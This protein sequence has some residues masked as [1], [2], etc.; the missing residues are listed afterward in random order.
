MNVSVLISNIIHMLIKKDKKKLINKSKK[1]N[2][3][4]V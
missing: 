1:P 2:L 3:K 4:L